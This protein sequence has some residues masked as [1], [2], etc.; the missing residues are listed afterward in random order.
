MINTVG[1]FER[2]LLATNTTNRA[3][4]RKDREAL[5]GLM[6]RLKNHYPSCALKA[7]LTGT[8]ITRN[9]IGVLSWNSLILPKSHFGLKSP[10][11]GTMWLAKNVTKVK[12]LDL[13]IFENAST[14]WTLCVISYHWSSRHLAT[15]RVYPTSPST[16]NCRFS[17]VWLCKYI[18]IHP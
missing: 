1:A 5:C 10:V 18:H 13:S 3:Q 8:K 11:I 7:C 17:T 15:T 14:W 9:L 6:F 2:H 16:R 4:G 12:N